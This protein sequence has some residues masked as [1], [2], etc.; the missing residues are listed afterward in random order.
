M[1]ATRIGIIEEQKVPPDNRAPL[2]PQ[3]ASDLVK[4]Y[5]NIAMTVEASDH[6]CFKDEEYEKADVPVKES[7]EDCELL[8]GIKEVPPD[9]LIEGKTY[10]FFSHTIKKQPKNRKLLQ[11]ILKKN[12]RLID[13]EL[14]TD[15]NGNRLLGFG[16]FAGLVGAHYALL[17]WGQRTGSFTVPPAH[18]CKN[19]KEVLR[20]YDKV[21][22]PPAKIV[23]TGTGRAAEGAIQFLESVGIEEVSKE[24]FL[25]RP[26]TESMFV[27]LGSADLYEHRYQQDYDRED[28]HVNPQNYRSLFGQYLEGTDILINAM[29]W[30]PRAPRLFKVEDVESGRVRIQTIADVTCDIEGSVPVTVKNSVRTAPVYGYNRKSGELGQPFETQNLDVMSISNLPNELPRD[31]SEEFGQIL[32]TQILPR[33]QVN[34]EDEL[35]ERATIARDGQLTE[36]FRYL[37]KWVREKSE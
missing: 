13:Y 12:I 31:A 11:Q 34:P 15:T 27:Q 3:Q 9:A 2:T 1:T 8:L 18:E 33:Y 6:R 7:V 28:F 4:H 16:R 10:M 29:Y 30:D 37:Q 5:P 36:P 14:L 19:L 25:S 20:Q 17:M 24:E 23:I 22:V 35:F 21:E 26:A 32:G